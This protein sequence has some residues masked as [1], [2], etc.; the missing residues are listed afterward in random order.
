[1]GNSYNVSF[2]LDRQSEALPEQPH[3][4]LDVGGVKT[5]ANMAQGNSRS[6]VRQSTAPIPQQDFRVA[7]QNSAKFSLAVFRDNASKCLIK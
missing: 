6:T 1:V 5:A 4:R 7:P 3:E 2:I